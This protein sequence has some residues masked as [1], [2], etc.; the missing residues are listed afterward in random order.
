MSN[1][2]I[3]TRCGEWPAV[4]DDSDISNEIWLSL[5][6]SSDINMLGSQIYFV[7]RSD[8]KVKGDSKTFEKGDIAYWPEA[9]A[10]CIFFGPT[11]LSAADGRPVAAYPMKKIGRVNGECSDMEMSGDRMRIT[12]ERSF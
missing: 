11:P 6:F 7:M 3:R 9:D 10:V 12:L 4:L 8:T 1:I 5:P 2:K